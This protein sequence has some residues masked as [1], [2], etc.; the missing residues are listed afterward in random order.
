MSDNRHTS[1]RFIELLEARNWLAWVAL[2]VPD[3]VYE[4]PQTRERINGRERYLLFNQEYP[5][6]W[7]L[8]ARVVLADER[9]GAV[10]FDWR[11]GDETG[12]GIVFFSFDAAGAIT[13]VTDFWPETYE[14]PAGRE[15]LV[16][17]W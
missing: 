15:H 14:P 9:E 2:M 13:G 4:M 12:D 10:W 17:R 6:D 3:V 5:G 7:H 1:Q 16:E 11:L 8:A